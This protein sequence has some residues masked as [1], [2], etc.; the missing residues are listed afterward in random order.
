MSEIAESPRHE[1]NCSDQRGVIEG[2][3]HARWCCRPNAIKHFLPSAHRG[4]RNGG[5]DEQC[6]EHHDALYGIRPTDAKK[7][8]D[9]RI[10][11]DARSTDDKRHSIVEREDLLE[12]DGTGDKSG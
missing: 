2:V 1:R 7:T 6:E 5:H 11:Q 9:R 8:A 4:N 12:E 3:E 10:G